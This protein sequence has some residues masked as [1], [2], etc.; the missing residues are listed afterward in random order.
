MFFGFEILIGIFVGVLIA[1]IVVLIMHI[2]T[3]SQMSKLT[4]PA[5]EYAMKK[6]EYDAESIVSEA[7][8]RA[9]QIIADAEKEGHK[10]ISGYTNQAAE[11]HKK[12]REV[13][14]I[15][16]DSIGQALHKASDV[17]VQAL[18]KVIASADGIIK[19]EQKKILDSV[20]GTSKHM[21][22][23]ADEAQKKAQGTMEGLQQSID[24]AGKKIQVQLE[25]AEKKGEEKLAKHLD[26]LQGVA[27]A[28]IDK[29]EESRKKLVDAH[30]EQLVEAVAMKVLHT[31]LPVTE[32]T[33]LAREALEEAKSKHIL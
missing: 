16:T 15:Q 18:E 3:T 24:E 21:A 30:I 6:A 29:Y 19:G 17:Q 25:R 14:A 13:I 5:Y 9:R 22:Q 4:L 2:R 33:S 1:A 10:T 12:Y 20:A 11:I 26:S 8:K 32:H 27:D 31:K 7:K 23:M 28:H